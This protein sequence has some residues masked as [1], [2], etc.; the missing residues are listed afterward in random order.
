MNILRVR[1]GLRNGRRIGV[2]LASL[3]LTSGHAFAADKADPASPANSDPAFKFAEASKVKKARWLATGN[4]GLLIASGN[5]NVTTFNGGVFVSWTDPNNRFTFD[6]SAAYSRQHSLTGVDANGNGRIEANEIHS[7]SHA[8]AENWYVRPRYDRFLSEVDSLYI[9]PAATS[10]VLAGK[11]LTLGGQLGYAR[12]LYSSEPHEITAE[13]GYDFTHERYV[14][15]PGSSL[16]I[17]S[18]RL[19]T[20]YRLK[21]ADDIFA[22]TSAE[23]LSNVA[24]EDTPSGRVGAF[25]DTRVNWKNI[26]SAKVWRN[27]SARF[28]FTARFDNWPAPRP[29]FALPYADGVV[30]SADK[31][32][33]Q[34]EF[35]MVVN[36]L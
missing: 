26:L 19:F 14:E 8:G 27:I 34:T 15:P 1:N 36:F 25:A 4:L 17:H 11:E 13:L 28:T 9:S 6:A 12:K 32:D 24:A 29:P 2:L 16:S 35:A 33:T 10:D 5:S 20:S 30:V 21:L 22:Q 3:L 23:L 18:A 31:L 7:E